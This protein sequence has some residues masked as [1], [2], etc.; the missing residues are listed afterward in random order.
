MLGEIVA[1]RLHMVNRR[2]L[3]VRVRY[4]VKGNQVDPTVKPVQ[5]TEDCITV[6]AAVIEGGAEIKQFDFGGGCAVVIG[7]EGRGL[8][9]EHAEMC[10]DRVTIEM[11][12]H[13]DSLNA[14]TA[15]T[16]FLWEMTRRGD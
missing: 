2:G 1:H 12:G 3:K 13:I 5:Q 15:A 16:I 14:A 4:R 7:N 6:A 9:R 8:S 11:H 10:S